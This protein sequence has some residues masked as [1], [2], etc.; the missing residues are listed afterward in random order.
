MSQSIVNS[1]R[2]I[3]ICDDIEVIRR[4]RQSNKFESLPI[5]LVTAFDKY[6][7]LQNIF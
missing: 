6:V 7:Q 4:I 3:L 1:I 2:R 5:L